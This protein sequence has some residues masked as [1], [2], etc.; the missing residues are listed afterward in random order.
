MKMFNLFQR[1]YMK[2]LL[3]VMTFTVAVC[4]SY[5]AISKSGIYISYSES[6]DYFEI[7]ENLSVANS[8]VSKVYKNHLKNSFLESS[9]D[10]Q[11]LGWYQD[12]RKNYYKTFKETEGSIFSELDLVV[13]PI[14]ES[15]FEANRPLLAITNL[16]DKLKDD[17]LQQLGKFYEHFNSKIAEL[18]R[19]SA[20]REAEVINLEKEL[21]K[22]NFKAIL[23]SAATF[24]SIPKHLSNYIKVH[25][26]WFPKE[27][28]M[29]VSYAK[30][31]FQQL[32][33]LGDQG[34]RPYWMWLKSTSMNPN[35]LHIRFYGL[36]LPYDDP[37]WKTHYPRSR[38]GC[39]CGI[40]SLSTKE[41]QE[42][43]LEVNS[44]NS[45]L[46]DLTKNDLYKQLINQEQNSS[47]HLLKA[48]EPQT[49]IYVKSI[50]DQLKKM[51]KV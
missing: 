43:G 44:G 48:W 33:L 12:F 36:V 30:G 14:M 3:V 42:R 39:K 7:M 46:T 16:K 49:N 18:V 11:W 45:F 5:A 4:A 28:D 37:F 2:I 47:L 32:K 35:P 50:G 27:E 10:K 9:A 15:F 34:L 23:N 22:A 24:F 26:V 1:S 13:D 20:A 25:F 8:P 40:R 19:V 51:L 38:W 41:I 31:Q 6:V 21:K 29:Q 17:Q